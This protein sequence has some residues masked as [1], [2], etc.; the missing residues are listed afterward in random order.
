MQVGV[1]CRNNWLRT[2]S[3]NVYHNN[4]IQLR[5]MGLTVSVRQ[6]MWQVQCWRDVHEKFSPSTLTGVFRGSRDEV[7]EWNRWVFGDRWQDR[8]LCR[9]QHQGHPMSRKS[10]RKIVTRLVIK[11]QKKMY[12]FWVYE[13]QQHTK[14][15]H[16]NF[17]HHPRCQECIRT[18]VCNA[19]S[20]HYGALARLNFN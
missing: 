5:N 16:I 13:I 11:T 19:W 8:S 9:N 7:E 4:I 18:R 3:A 10:K 2:R 17:W 14:I 20:L 6:L 1:W 15:I 12:V